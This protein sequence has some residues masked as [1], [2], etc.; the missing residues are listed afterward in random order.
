MAARS[1]THGTCPSP[2]IP[3]FPPPS[4]TSSSLN[5]IREPSSTSVQPFFWFLVGE[6]TVA[7]DV[8]SLVQVPELDA[9]TPDDRVHPSLAPAQ[10]YH[11][12]HHLL[13][14]APSRALHGYFLAPRLDTLDTLDAPVPPCANTCSAAPRPPT[15]PH[16][17]GCSAAA[18]PPH[19]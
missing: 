5:H 4:N 1:T 11:R 18:P 13:V 10:A 16:R 2:T 14:I 19:T 7:D 6:I 12:A 15:I 17:R 8:F 9:R 3:R